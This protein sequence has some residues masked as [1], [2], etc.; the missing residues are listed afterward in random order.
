MFRANSELCINCPKMSSVIYPRWRYL[1]SFFVSNFF[2]FLLIPNCTFLGMKLFFIILSNAQDKEYF[3]IEIIFLFPHC[4]QLSI[5][6]SSVFVFIC[7]WNAR[8][9]VEIKKVPVVLVPFGRLT[10]F[11]VWWS[12]SKWSL[13]DGCSRRLRQFQ[14]ISCGIVHKVTIMVQTQRVGH[15]VGVLVLASFFFKG[16]SFLV[17]YKFQSPV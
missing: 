13:C 6:T 1:R 2:C 16:L 17:K 4:V 5:R 14:E 8:R 9:I 10:G 15:I 12:C 7:L 11:L 3:N